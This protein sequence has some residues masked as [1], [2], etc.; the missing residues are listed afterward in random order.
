LMLHF[1]Q[2]PTVGKRLIDKCLMAARAREAARKA[3]ETVRKGALT[4][5]G[6]PGKLADCSER[7]PALTELYVVEG[8]S[9]GGSAKQGRDRR[10]QAILPIKGKIINVEKARLDKVLQ[11]TEIQTLITAIG[12]GIG[13]PTSDRD[14]EGSFNIEKLRYGR[15]IIMTDADVDGSHI[16]TLLLTFFYR[17]MP[18]LVRQGK[19]YIACPPLYLIKRKKREE[20]VDDDAQLNKILITL[21][22]DEVKLKNLADGK[23][24]TATQLKDILDL[25]ERLAKFND[26]IR[27]HGGDFESYLQQRDK[28]TGTLPAFMVKV[29]EGNAEWAKYFPNDTEVRSFHEGNRDLNLF[30]DPAPEPVEGDVTTVEAKTKKEKVDPASRRRARLIELHESATVQKLIDEL[31][32][33]GLK[34]EHYADSDTPIFEM[35]EGEGDKAVTHPLF[36]IPEILQKVLEI[37]KK[38]LSIQRFKGLGEMNPKQLFETTMNPDKRKMMKVDLN[39]DNAVEADRMFTILMGDV[40]EPRR[41]FIE[42]NALNARLDV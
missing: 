4:G 16:R 7:D 41:Q 40:V 19:I 33:K 8:D 30:D 5:G 18:E 36:T 42:D 34:I 3:R 12:T 22:A 11:N 31:A 20:Y 25:L 1:D 9:A 26:S 35:T 37:G 17:Q 15:I 2:N 24:F 13:S 32:R 38:G 10:F 23:I 27:R 6:L 14:T 21:G 39:E 29:R 28:Q